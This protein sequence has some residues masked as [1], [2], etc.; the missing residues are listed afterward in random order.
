MGRIDQTVETWYLLLFC[1]LIINLQLTKT[2]FNKAKEEIKK[3]NKWMAIW[4][5]PKNS[6]N[7]IYKND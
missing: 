4:V 5:R 7:S 6:T 1:K 2:S 3:D